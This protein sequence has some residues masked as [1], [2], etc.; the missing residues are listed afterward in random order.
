MNSSIFRKEVNSLPIAERPGVKREG[1]L[2]LT[3]I[4]QPKS[5]RS[6]S[7]DAALHRLFYTKLLCALKPDEPQVRPSSPLHRSS[8]SSVP[9]IYQASPRPLSRST[10][11]HLVGKRRS[12]ARRSAPL[13]GSPSS[14][15]CPALRRG[16]PRPR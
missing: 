8:S 11:R 7:E 6:V 9:T 1:G 16:H 13:R 4:H 3:S 15:P 12:T 10:W 2:C 14:P 5:A